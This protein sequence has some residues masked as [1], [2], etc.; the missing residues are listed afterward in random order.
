MPRSL[1]RARPT[2]YVAAGFDAK[3]FYPKKIERVFNKK[4]RAVEEREKSFR[5]E[6]FSVVLESR[7]PGGRAPGFPSGPIRL[8]TGRYGTLLLAE[9][10]GTE[11]DEEG[12][13]KA[14]YRIFDRRR[15]GPETRG[16]LLAAVGPE[17]ADRIARFLAVPNYDPP[18]SPTSPALLPDEY[19]S[20]GS[21]TLAS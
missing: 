3:V 6:H 8:T 7:E 14:T 21:A 19:E 15:P 11:V 17:S 1:R 16:F 18:A 13:E 4:T 5:V 2:I 20:R 10:I 12:N 9:R